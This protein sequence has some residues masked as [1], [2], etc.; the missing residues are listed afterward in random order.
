M[1][2]KDTYNVFIAV[3]MMAN[4]RHG[5]I[6]IG[7]TGKLP[8]RVY[9]HREGLVDGFTKTHGLKRL[10]WYEPMRA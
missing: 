3:Y 1:V 4:R 8:S 6:Y 9:E 10:V 2:S 5:T 7:V